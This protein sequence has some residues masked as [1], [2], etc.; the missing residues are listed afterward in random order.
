MVARAIG[1]WFAVGL[2]LGLLPIAPGTWGSLG[3]VGITLLLSHFAAG[4]V[5]L[6]L[7]LCFLVALIGG[8]F[9]SGLVEHH[10]G[11]RDPSCVVIDEVAGQ[12]LI[13]LIVPLS[14]PMIVVG[15]VLFRIFDVA[16]PFPCRH[17]ESLPGGLGIMMDDVVAGA[18]V[19]VLILLGLQ[20]YAILSVAG[21]A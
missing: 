19:G 1:Y 11:K 14:V 9:A 4:Y 3:A 21:G 2:G 17:A 16:K 15:F 7:W 20:V 6:L 8:V 18:Y 10:L 13:Y 12:L 5:Y